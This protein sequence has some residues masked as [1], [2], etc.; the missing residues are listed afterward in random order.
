MHASST[1]VRSRRAFRASEWRGRGLAAVVLSS[2]SCCGAEVIAAPSQAATDEA[3]AQTF[4]V[5]FGPLTPVDRQNIPKLERSGGTGHWAF[6]PIVDYAPPA[7]SSDWARNE[8]DLFVLD[9]LASQALDPSPRAPALTLLKRVHLDLTGLLPT[10]DEV[11]WFLAEPDFDAAYAQVVDALLASDHFGERWGAHWLDAA[12]YADSDGYAHDEPRTIWPYRDYVIQAFNSDLPFDQ[13][14]IE[15]LAGDL[16]DDA[17][18]RE[19]TAV[20]FHRNSMTNTEGG[21][22]VEEF[23]VEAVKDRVNTTAKVFLGVTLECAQCHNHLYDPFTQEDYYRLYAFFNDADEAVVNVG[24]DV[25]EVELLSFAPLNEPRASFVQLR[26]DFL[27]AGPD[28]DPGV[29]SVLPPLRVEH[30]AN[31]LDLAQWLTSRQQ[32][33]TPRVTVNRIWQALFGLGLVKTEDD[34]GQR[35]EA[36]THPQLLDWL[37]SRFMDDWSFKSLIRRIV[38]SATY[39]QASNVRADLD[40]PENRWLARQQRLRVEAEIVRDV[41]LQAAGLLD[42]RVGGPSV[43]PPVVRGV[44][45]GGRGAQ[46]WRTSEGADRYRRGVYT[47]LYRTVP[48]P[49]L[50]VFDAP[51]GLASVTRR[52]RSSTPLQALTLLNDEVFFEAALV[53]GNGLSELGLSDDETLEYA[54]VRVLGRPPTQKET[55]LLSQL[56]AEERAIPQDQSLQLWSRFREP[57]G[58][59]VEA[60]AWAMVGRVLLNLD[61][62]ITR[63]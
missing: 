7:V 31:R 63:E 22:D 49:S 50:A 21:I 2:I 5:E 51:E 14:V 28:V 4:P 35:G 58:D 33:L 45:E 57:P 11:A 54:V 44:L 16:L 30:R 55:A 56:L 40:D 8:I 20:A 39:Q 18:E 36:P 47:F 9:A 32:P 34:F 29:P 53:L 38:F 26:G 15:Q 60:T 62:T 37:A 46:S 59:V 23:R 24:T 12:R 17:G 3:D 52:A 48:Y 61:E 10:P 13:F 6:E 19:L 1:A 42:L 27:N 41:T 43:Y 25:G